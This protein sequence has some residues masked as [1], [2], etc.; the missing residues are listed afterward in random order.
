MTWPPRGPVSTHTPTRPVRWALFPFYRWESCG[1]LNPGL[2]DSQVMSP[3]FASGM[4]ISPR[5][6]TP[7][8]QPRKPF[9][10]A[11]RAWEFIISPSPWLT[12]TS[13]RDLAGR[14]GMRIK[15]PEEE[16]GSQVP[17]WLPRPPCDAALITAPAPGP[18][19]APQPPVPK[20]QHRGMVHTSAPQPTMGRPGWG[21]SSASASCPPRP[22][23]PRS[24]A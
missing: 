19:L 12:R 7:A 20:P 1:E 10:G 3:R 2:P 13:H 24:E 4:L 9:H 6:T 5:K 14:W 18:F 11:G 8:H 17:V 23:A 22:P 16:L 21:P 15:F